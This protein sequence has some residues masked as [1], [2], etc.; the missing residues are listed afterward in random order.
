MLFRSSG[1]RLRVGTTSDPNSSWNAFFQ[2][3]SSQ[4]A[5]VTYGAGASASGLA[6]LVDNTSSNLIGLYYGN[7]SSFSNVGSI[8]TNGSNTSYNTSSD[9]RLKENVE[10]Y[11]NAITRLK[12]LQPKTFTWIANPA[13]GR[14]EGFIAHELQ[15]V[16]PEAVSGE[17]DAV[18]EDGSIK[19][20]GIDSS[21]LVPMLTAALQ[22]AVAK[23]EA[24]EARVQ[25]LGG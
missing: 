11:T 21:F 1:G 9:Y 4:P 18:Y 14:S 20:Q 19:P 15:A 16:L 13:L 17:K 10:P 23:I 24:L 12:Q 7:P 3:Q 5:A 22:E 2:N 8:S 25:A 6:V